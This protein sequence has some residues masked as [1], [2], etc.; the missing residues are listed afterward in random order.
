VLRGDT[1]GNHGTRVIAVAHWHSLAHHSLD[2]GIWRP[3]RLILP[4]PHGRYGVRIEAR[5]ARGLILVRFRQAIPS[6]TLVV[7][8]RPTTIISSGRIRSTR[9]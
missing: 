1:G 9:V 2:L 6:P 8:V 7:C 3:A 4:N 5:H